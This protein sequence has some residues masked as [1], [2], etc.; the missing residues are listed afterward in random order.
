MAYTSKKTEHPSSIVRRKDLKP[1]KKQSD[2]ALMR[3]AKA[4]ATMH[5]HRAEREHRA[6]VADL[7]AAREE[8][9]LRR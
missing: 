4:A 1:A 8:R 9:R 3:S 7:E 2:E 5:V 6:E